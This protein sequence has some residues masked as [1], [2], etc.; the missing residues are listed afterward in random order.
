MVKS[1]LK[2]LDLEKKIKKRR[3]TDML[4]IMK[5]IQASIVEG[6]DLFTDIV[7][8]NEIYWEGMKPENKD[9]DSFKI[10]KEY[11][12]L[13]SGL[14]HYNENSDGNDDSINHIE[15]CIEEKLRPH[16]EMKLAQIVDPIHGKESK[17][18]YRILEYHKYREDEKEA[19]ERHDKISENANKKY[20]GVKRYLGMKKMWKLVYV[21]T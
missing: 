7:L 9:K 2:E 19:D 5:S 17:T 18:L 14:L 13:V 21:K 15:Y 8:L 4:T 11:F 12:A 3:F 16:P 20:N 10:Q 1:K 6:L